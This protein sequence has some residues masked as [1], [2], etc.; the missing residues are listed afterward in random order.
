ME[1]PVFEITDEELSVP[2][3]DLGAPTELALLE[4]PDN[5]GDIPQV[6]GGG[7]LLE[8]DLGAGPGYW[9]RVHANPDVREV[10]QLSPCGPGALELL[11]PLLQLPGGVLLFLNNHL[12][13]QT[14]S[15]FLHF[16]RD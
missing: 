5:L 6:P 8:P 12:F 16:T 15:C 7:V 10:L 9:G 14:Q 11:D 3:L 4:L 13:I 2:E 1:D